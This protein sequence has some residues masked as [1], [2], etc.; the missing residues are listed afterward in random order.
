MGFQ[1]LLQIVQTVNVK[2]TI[3]S[4]P[5]S[6]LYHFYKSG[7]VTYLSLLDYLKRA[8][9]AV[10]TLRGTLL[11]SWVDKIRNTYRKLGTVSE[12]Q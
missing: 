8:M 9:S 7:Q 6:Q 10:P 4:L 11:G 1:G 3:L 5:L 2:S 12:A